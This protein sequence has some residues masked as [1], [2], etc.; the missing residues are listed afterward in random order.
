MLLLCG[1]NSPESALSD[2]ASVEREVML[3]FPEVRPV[4]DLPAGVIWL[5]EDGPDFYIYRLQASPESEI[6]GGIYFGYA[7]AYNSL[8]VLSSLA[9]TFAS[10][11]ITWRISRHQTSEKISVSYETIIIYP[12]HQSTSE[13]NNALQLHVWLHAPTKEQ[14]EPL[15]ESLSNLSFEKRE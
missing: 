11:A 3:S 2:D 10:Q 14:L 12:P 4:A 8:E 13:Q 1:C 7:P 15:L 5:F 6:G 9:G